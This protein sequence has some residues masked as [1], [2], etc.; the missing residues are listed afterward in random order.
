[1]DEENFVPTGIRSP[2]RPA[3]NESL[4]RLSYRG[5]SL[6]VYFLV[7]TSS[8]LQSIFHVLKLAG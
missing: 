6:Q 7:Y 1:M 4:Y 5:P 8:H 3:R 2:D